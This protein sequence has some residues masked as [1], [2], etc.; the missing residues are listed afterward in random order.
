MTSLFFAG[1]FNHE[2][3]QIL[4]KNVL[5][6][7]IGQRIKQARLAKGLK[8]EELASKLVPS[9]TAASISNIEKGAQ[10]IYIDFL[11]EV[12]IILGVGVDT[13]CPSIEEVQSK[14]PSI[15]KE[16]EKYPTKEQQLVKDL[17]DNAGAK[18]KED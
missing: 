1:I 4:M 16:L 18:E 7:L 13:F 6:P 8:Q 11:Y 3:F 17:I 9:R 5:Y 2:P 10:R 12:A 15:E 14:V